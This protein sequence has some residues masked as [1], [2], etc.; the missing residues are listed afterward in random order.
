MDRNV[1]RGPG[2][3]EWPVPVRQK[4]VR[5]VAWTSASSWRSTRSSD[6]LLTFSSA[7]S[8]P[9]T[10]AVAPCASARSGSKRSLNRP[11]SIRAIRGC[12]ASVDEM[13]ACDCAKP[14]C[15]RYLA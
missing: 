14:I 4:L 6:R 8:M 11:T 2:A 12:A 13:V 10:C 3:P 7:F 15:L 9:L 5:S 1:R